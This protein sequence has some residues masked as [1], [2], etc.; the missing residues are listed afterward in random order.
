MLGIVRGNARRM[1]QLIDDLLAF[2]RLG[3]QEPVLQAIDMT[4]L[5]R[6]VADELRGTQPVA[7]ELAELPPAKADAALLRQVW[8]NLIGNAIKYSSKKADARVVVAARE[9]AEQNVYTVT[10]NG[11]G[12]DMRY[13]DKL[14]GVFQRLHR[15]EDFEGTGIGLA[16][17]RRI[18]ARHGGRTWAEGAVGQGA[19][20]HFTLP[21][22]PAPEG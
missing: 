15:M 8:A 17:V 2:S 12:F 3:R 9:D 16:N 4:R 18:V 7:I 20:F 14:F 19:T 11:A 10:D 6:E 22:D 1:G 5:A 13:V 21:N